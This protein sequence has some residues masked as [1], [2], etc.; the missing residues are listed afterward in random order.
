MKAFTI[1]NLPKKQLLFLAHHLFSGLFEAPRVSSRQ[2]ERESISLVIKFSRS[3]LRRR[4][5][6]FEPTTVR[7]MAPSH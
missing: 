6:N 2:R 4:V 3:N 5:N 1:F 7:L